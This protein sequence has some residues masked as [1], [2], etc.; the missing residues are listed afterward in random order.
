MSHNFKKTV[1]ENFRIRLIAY[2]SISFLLRFLDFLYQLSGFTYFATEFLSP[3]SGVILFCCFINWKGDAFIIEKFD[4]SSKDKNIQYEGEVDIGEE[5]VE[6]AS[7]EE[8]A[9][10]KVDIE[11]RNIK[12]IVF[13]RFLSI[14]GISR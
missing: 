2:S 14:F 9:K 11:Y 12:Q 7:E 5:A 3:W 10:T 1:A 13:N 4:E 8:S 6:K